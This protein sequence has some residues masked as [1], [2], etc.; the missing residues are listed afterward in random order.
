LTAEQ[1]QG[2]ELVDLVEG[3]LSV[4]CSEP[5]RMLIEG[6]SVRLLPQP[7]L[8]FALALHELCTNAV[9]YGALS[10]DKGRVEV[11]WRVAESGS[12]RQLRLLWQES[13]GPEVQPPTSRGFGSRLIEKYLG[14]QLQGAVRWNFQRD[15]VVCEV[16]APWDLQTLP[17]DA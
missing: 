17:G 6:P 14:T 8:T 7:S 5:S 9:K 2:A 11:T 12:Q 1:W 3:S 15:G 16:V 10:N 13:G 4:H